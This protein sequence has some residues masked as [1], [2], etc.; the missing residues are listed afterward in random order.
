M[1]VWNIYPP[2]TYQQILEKSAPYPI[3]NVGT[4]YD[5]LCNMQKNANLLS[6]SPLANSNSAPPFRNKQTR[7]V[8]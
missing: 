3:Q 1:I 7:V 6:G 8:A 2:S 5:T 4:D